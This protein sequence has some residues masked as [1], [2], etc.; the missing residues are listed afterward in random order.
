MPLNLRIRVE[1]YHL[2]SVA[3]GLKLVDYYKVDTSTVLNTE[4]NDSIADFTSYG[5]V[6]ED[7]GTYAI[8]GNVGIGTTSPDNKLHVVDGHIAIEAAAGEGKLKFRA[9]G[10]TR[11]EIYRDTSDVT[12]LRNWNQDYTI[13]KIW[14]P[15]GAVVDDREATL[16]LARGDNN[17]EMVDVFNNGYVTA[18]DPY[19][20]QYGIRSLRRQGSG[21]FRDFVFD[22][23]HK[24]P[25]NPT[26]VKLPAIMVLKPTRKVGIGIRENLTARLNIRGDFTA[27]GTVTVQAGSQSTVT[28]TDTLFT[29]EINVGDKIKIVDT[30]ETRAVTGIT[31]DTSLTVDSDFTPEASSNMTVINNLLRLDDSSGTAKVFVNDQGNVGIGTTSPKFILHATGGAVA[32]GAPNAAPTDAD[33]N[34]SNISFWIDESGAT[35]RL[36]VRVKLSDG[37]LKTATID[38]A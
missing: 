37:T 27:K 26:P 36:K 12:I 4:I 24:I 18:G 10:T 14:A 33:L 11:N 34:N 32:V 29:A 28:G 17:D 31:S 1:G 16:S 35:K 5:Q 30:G 6:Y 13:L 3:D 20:P 7:A 22:Q 21:E 25:S 19:G 15:T 23:C 9:S 2:S 8:S 38:L